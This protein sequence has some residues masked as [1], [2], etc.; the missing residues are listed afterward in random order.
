MERPGFTLI[1]LLVVIAIIAV[2]AALLLPVLGKAR[3]KANQAKCLNRL[4]QLQTA[5]ISYASENNGEFPPRSAPPPATPTP[6]WGYP[7]EFCDYAL[8]LGRYLSAPRDLA[9]FCP[10][11]L[12]QVRNPGSAGGYDTHFTTYQYFNYSK[13]FLGTYS[14]GKPDLFRMMTAP[15]SVALWGCLTATKPDGAALAHHEPNVKTP[16]SGMNAVYPDGHALWVEG[17]GLEV[18]FSDGSGTA[19]MWP[20]PPALI[21]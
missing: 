12:M 5:C 2:L 9:L 20:K 14:T 15:G 4:V 1:E 8:T 17:A 7:H 13:P 11:E 10:G 19:Y 18:Y 3:S 21:P 16:V 6:V